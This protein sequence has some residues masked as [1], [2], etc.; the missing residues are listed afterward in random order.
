MEMTV[1][2]AVRL[3]ALTQLHQGGLAEGSNPVHAAP[4]QPAQA[5]TEAP[6]VVAMDHTA[7]GIQSAL[8]EHVPPTT[9]AAA[10]RDFQ[11]NGTVTPATLNTMASSVG[12]TP[13]QMIESLAD[14]GQAM[15]RQGEKAFASFGIDKQDTEA[16]FDH[17]ERK[18]PELLRRAN[19][20]HLRGDLSGIREM[21]RHYHANLA[22]IDPGR[23]LESKFGNGITAQMSGKTV[24][25]NVPGKGQM[26]YSAAVRAGIVTVRG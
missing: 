26:S 25:L 11:R 3:G 5:P 2:N 9:L 6:M 18:N 20:Q 7:Q 17:L 15:D 12:I 4:A 16:L 1:Q 19:M 22:E 13:G 10:L 23:I 14:L 21:A 24:I 8:M